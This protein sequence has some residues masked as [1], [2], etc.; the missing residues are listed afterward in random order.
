VTGRVYALSK[1]LSKKRTVRDGVA[2]A[3]GEIVG[4]PAI[5]TGV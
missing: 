1:R 5:N 2:T 4:K 3:I